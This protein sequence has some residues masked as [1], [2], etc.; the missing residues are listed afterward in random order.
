MTS[1]AS[2][3]DLGAETFR[4]YAEI[5]TP[6]GIMPKPKFQIPNCCQNPKLSPKSQ[7]VAE[8]PNSFRNPKLLP[9]SQITIGQLVS[10][11]VTQ[12]QKRKFCSWQTMKFGSQNSKKGNFFDDR[13]ILFGN[14]LGF[15]QQFGILTTI[16][17]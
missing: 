1:N 13:L 14:N 9:K 16:W 11:D 2:E 12:I 15:R 7:I 8:I 10:C 5:K 3:I 17:D 4:L 6:F